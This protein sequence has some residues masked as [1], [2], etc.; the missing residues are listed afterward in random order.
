MSSILARAPSIGSASGS[1]SGPTRQ[2][3]QNSLFDQFA[4]QAKGMLKE[5]QSSQ[6]GSFLQQVDKVSLL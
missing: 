2:G 6:E 4:H 3:S 1:G 5:R